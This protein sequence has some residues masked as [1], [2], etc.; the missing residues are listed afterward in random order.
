MA[1]LT[2]LVEAVTQLQQQVQTLEHRLNW[3]QSHSSNYNRFDPELTS[4]PHWYRNSPIFKQPYKANA[5]HHHMSAPVPNKPKNK[6]NAPHKGRKIKQ[7]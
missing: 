7:A 3:E 5:N 6:V 4:I 1:T 2:G